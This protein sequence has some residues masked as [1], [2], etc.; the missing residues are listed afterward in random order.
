MRHGSQAANFP[1][2]ENRLA[3]NAE[4]RKTVSSE[5]HMFI[6][7]KLINGSAQSFSTIEKRLSGG[8][9]VADLEL[10][11]FT[12]STL[13]LIETRQVPSVT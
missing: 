11:T 12:S 4:R 5:T 7:N 9:A 13:D 6:Q 3:H 10:G 8:C 1:D 2:A